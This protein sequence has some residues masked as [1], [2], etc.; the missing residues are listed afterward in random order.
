MK[1]TIAT[2]KPIFKLLGAEEN[3]HANYPDCAHDFPENVRKVAYDFL[4]KH[5]LGK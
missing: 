2:A 4:D 1:D 3:L 5:L